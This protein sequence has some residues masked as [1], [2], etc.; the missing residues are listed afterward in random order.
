MKTTNQATVVDTT[1]KSKHPNADTLSVINVMGYN[2]CAKTSDWEGVDKGIFI[3]P[4]N[5]VDTQRP[6]FSFLHRKR[7]WE[8]V[9]VMR[10]R[11]FISAGLLI[12]ALPTDNVGD[13]ATERLGIL[14]HDPEAQFETKD[15]VKP[16]T[17]Q[18]SYL[19][20]YDID[21]FAKIYK[22]FVESDQIVATCKIHGQNSRF[23]YSTADKKFFVGARGTW[24]EDGGIC[25]SAVKHHPGI[26]Q[27]CID[28]PDFILCGEVYG[29][30]GG[31][32]NYGLPSK[33]YGFA[34]FDI[35]K[36]DFQFLDYDDFLSCCS[37]YGIPTVSELY[38]GPFTSLDF[39]KSFAEGQDPLCSKTPREGCVVKLV[40]DRRC[41]SG[42]RM[43]FKIIGSGYK[44]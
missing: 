34:A 27:F 3:P 33:H 28:N 2:V 5:L 15:Q 24:Q 10:L 13:D 20:K 26:Q 31:D 17:G 36:P 8:K 7:Q 22:Y 12:P 21:S 11:G 40:K 6:E 35:R 43:T 18:L 1:N 30:Q 4:E 44:G 39:L 42:D 16:P 38:R 37:K 9:K 23:V 14:H 32:Y 41:E 19:P 25:W 29:Q